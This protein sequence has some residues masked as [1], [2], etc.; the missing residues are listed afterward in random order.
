MPLEDYYSGDDSF[1]TFARTPDSKLDDEFQRWK[2]REEL[3]TLCK[4]DILLSRA[5]FYFHRSKSITFM[6]SKIAAL[7]GLTP[8]ECLESWS[9]TDRL[10]ECI[11]RSH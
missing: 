6:N 9:G 8:I 4:N 10:K 2:R 11:L 1:Y 7:E 5:I 3:I